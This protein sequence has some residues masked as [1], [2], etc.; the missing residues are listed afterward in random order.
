MICFRTL[1][2]PFALFLATYPVCHAQT[3]NPIRIIQP[4]DTAQVVRIAGSVPPMAKREFDQ[5]RLNGNM[6]IHGVSLVC[7][8]SSA[9]QRDLQKLLG[10]QQDRH[11]LRYHKWLTPE[12]FAERFGLTS[13]DVAQLTAWLESEGFVVD[14][15]ARSRTKVSFIGSVAQIES[16]GS[17]A[18]ARGR[19]RR[20]AAPSEKG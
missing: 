4:I 14:R 20:A 16:L 6:I 11:S 1:F 19:Q 17:K 3:A 13:S 12:Q 10:E 8:R 15:V 9:Q 5:G 2:V 7:K 18:R